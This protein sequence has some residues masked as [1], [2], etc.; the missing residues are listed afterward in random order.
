M[1]NIPFIIVP[2]IFI[3]FDV[4]TGVLKAIKEKNLSSTKAREGLYHKTGF[5]LLI[6]F[7]TFLN[8]AQNYFTLGIE[9]PVLQAVSVYICATE[10]I[11]TLENISR[12]SPELNKFL[13]KFLEE[14]K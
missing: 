2:L 7:S 12:I 9:V 1:D 5:M 3:V 11:S 8:F 14:K 10:T 6:I 13:S 4:I